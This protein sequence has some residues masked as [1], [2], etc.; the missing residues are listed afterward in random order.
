MPTLSTR[1]FPF[2]KEEPVAGTKS[3]Y[4]FPFNKEIL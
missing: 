2:S 1:L 4:K 3:A